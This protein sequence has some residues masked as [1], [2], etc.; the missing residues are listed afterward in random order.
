[1]NMGE[2]GRKELN[3]YVKSDFSGSTRNESATDSSNI[4][5]K[6]LK[7]YTNA[8]LTLATSE[9]TVDIGGGNLTATTPTLYN[10]SLVSIM[11]TTFPSKRE[12]RTERKG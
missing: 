4:P 9:T 5:T 11:T 2:R 8:P 7:V 10:T 6:S 1:M 3:G 12:T